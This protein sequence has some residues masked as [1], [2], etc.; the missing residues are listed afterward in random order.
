MEPRFAP[1]SQFLAPCDSLTWPAL[2][3]FPCSRS[4]VLRANPCVPSVGSN[5]TFR[6]ALPTH[7]EVLL[8]GSPPTLLLCTL[9]QPASARLSVSPPAPTHPSPRASRTVFLS[10]M[11]MRAASSERSAAPA[12]CTACIAASSCNR[13]TRAEQEL[14]RETVVRDKSRRDD[15]A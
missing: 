3:P 13:C 10:V 1:A 6:Q 5:I 4:D 15:S 14:A 9:P 8:H 12:K 11:M 7:L 2:Q